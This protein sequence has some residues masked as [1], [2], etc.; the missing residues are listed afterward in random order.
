M[1]IPLIIMLLQGALGAFD[2]LFYHEYLCRLPARG[3]EVAGELRLHATRDF[4]YTLLFLTLPFWKWQGGLA[5]LLCCLILLEISIT[6]WDFNT[7]A[8]E[9]ASLGGV[10]NTERGLHLVMA[11]IYG[12]FLANLAPH[13]FS[14]LQMPLGFASQDSVPSWIKNLCIFFGVGVL[15]SGLRDLLAATGIRS[16][17]FDL[18]RRSL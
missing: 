3:S 5:I 10:S 15:A 11:V 9:R 16:L 4:V 17:Q 18:F 14:W 2:T 13:V 1:E 12:I 6:I 8:V 7:E